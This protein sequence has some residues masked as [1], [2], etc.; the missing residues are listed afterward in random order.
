M[1]LFWVFVMV[2]VADVVTTLWGIRLGLED[3]WFGRR[4]IPMLLLATAQIAGFYVIMILLPFVP[5]MEPV[6]YAVLAIRIGVVLWNV[7]LIIQKTHCFFSFLFSTDGDSGRVAVV[8]R[9]S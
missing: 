1:E 2:V 5:Y 3:V 4:V 6:V 8:P 7:Y 9:N